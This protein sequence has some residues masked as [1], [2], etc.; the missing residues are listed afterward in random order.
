MLTTPGGH[1]MI[2]IGNLADLGFAAVTLAIAAMSFPLA[3]D[4]EVTLSVATA[5]SVRVAIAN[6]VAMAI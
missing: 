6:P 4:R 1:L 5:T 2:V 3:L